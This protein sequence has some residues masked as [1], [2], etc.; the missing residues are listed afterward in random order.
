MFSLS[1]QEEKIFRR[2]DKPKKIQDFLDTL[3]INFEPKGDTCSSPRVVLKRKSAH[4]IEAAIFAAAVMTYHRQYPLLLDLKANTRDYDHV[5]CLFKSGKYYGAI[6]K[7]NHVTL[8][9]REPVYTSVRELAMSYFHEY[10]NDAG[11]KTLRSFSKPHSLKKYGTEWV[12][13]ADDLWE[14][15]NEL[16]EIKHFNILPKGLRLRKADKIELSAGKLIEWKSSSKKS[17]KI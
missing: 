4:C 16:D 11:E 17:A 3:S 13:S 2:L 10:I 8:R 1:K 15:A 6:S 5:V 9:Y 12:T 7:S 14:I